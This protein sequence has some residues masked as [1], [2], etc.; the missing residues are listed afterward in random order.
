MTTTYLLLFY[1]VCFPLRECGPKKE[2]LEQF[3]H[4]R[5][6]KVFLP[7]YNGRAHSNEGLY[8]E[9]CYASFCR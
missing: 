6:K 2:I 1:D 3:P 8:Y 4:S 9:S 7:R 5:R